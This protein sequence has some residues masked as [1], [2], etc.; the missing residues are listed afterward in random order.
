MKNILANRLKAINGETVTL[1]GFVETIRI[2]KNC[3]FIILRE[4]TGKIQ[5]YIGKETKVF[6]VAAL[7]TVESTIKVKGIVNVNPGQRTDGVEIIPEKIEIISIAAAPIPILENSPSSIKMDWR[8]LDLRDVKN[9]LIF[10]IQT[11]AEHAM[12]E[13]WIENDFVEIHSPKLMEVESE[14]GSE[15][16][17]VE[18]FDRIAYLAQSP[19]FYKQ[20]AMMSGFD[21]VFEIGPVFRANNSNTYRHDTEFV[22][23]DVE[24]SWIDSH[25]NLMNFEEEWIVYFLTKIKEKHEEKIKELYDKDVIVP[26]IPFPR[27]TMTEAHKILREMGYDDVDDNSDFTSDHEK[28]IAKY[29]YDKTGHEFL[30]VTE[31]PIDVRPFYHMRLESDN[32]YTKSYDLIW[33]GLEVTTGAQREHRYDILCKQVLEKGLTLEALE[34]YLNFFKYG[35]P[36]HGG[37]GFGLTRMLMTVLG[38]KNVREVTY[39]FRGPNRLTP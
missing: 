24:M 14:S 25:E 34:S 36:T 22:S 5:L 33:N 38:L 17:K 3:C 7:I 23:V 18:Y 28:A 21:K 6:E 37:F 29:F 1:F 35:A 8:Y 31:F 16:F 32:K 39:L 10:E 2:T 19:Q 9:K 26:K 15:I 13:F 30:F 12:R 20:M 27:I 4:N 11:T